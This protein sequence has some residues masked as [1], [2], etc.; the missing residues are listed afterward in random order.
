MPSIKTPVRFLEAVILD[1]ISIPCFFMSKKG[2]A[3]YHLKFMCPI[4]SNWRKS[5]RDPRRGNKCMWY[6]AWR[7]GCFEGPRIY[8][9]KNAV[10]YYLGLK[11]DLKKYQKEFK[12]VFRQA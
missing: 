6:G 7:K 9:I 3:L 1:S 11:T 4:C 12:K 2:L 10:R 5:F 8:G